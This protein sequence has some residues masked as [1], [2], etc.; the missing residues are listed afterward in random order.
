MASFEGPAPADL[1]FIKQAKDLRRCLMI[2]CAPTVERTDLACFAVSVYADYQ[3]S[4]PSRRSDFDDPSAWRLTPWS[5][6]LNTWNGCASWPYILED[7]AQDSSRLKEEM[8]RLPA[9]SATGC[10]SVI[11]TRPSSLLTTANPFCAASR[12]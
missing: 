8:L 12:W 7:E 2:C 4:W 3:R 9:G 1:N 6:S 10:A 11:L 5:A